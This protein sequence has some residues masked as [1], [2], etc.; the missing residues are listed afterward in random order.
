MNRAFTMIETGWSSASGSG[1][2]GSM[3]RQTRSGGVFLM[4]AILIGFGWGMANGDAMKG[5]VLG[6]AAGVGI[7]TAVWLADRRRG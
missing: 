7:V 1:M 5:V 2:T 4:L 6:A 3:E